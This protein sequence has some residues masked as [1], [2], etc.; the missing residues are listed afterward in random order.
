[1]QNAQG[2]RRKRHPSVPWLPLLHKGTNV[3][4]GTLCTH[5][6]RHMRK[7][8]IHDKTYFQVIR[9]LYQD[10]HAALVKYLAAPMGS[11]SRFHRCY[12][13]EYHHPLLHPV[14]EEP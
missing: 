3:E 5:G 2:Q 7:I 11:N 13:P 9:C 14:I 10:A 4:D 1:M 12:A 6:L 8:V